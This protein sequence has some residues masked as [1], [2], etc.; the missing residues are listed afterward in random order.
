M[1]LLSL[2]FADGAHSPPPAHFT[3]ADVLG[4]FATAFGLWL[5]I[6]ALLRGNGPL[7][8]GRRG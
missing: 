7:A 8:R 3:A 5:F 2:L 1:H 4:L 6:R